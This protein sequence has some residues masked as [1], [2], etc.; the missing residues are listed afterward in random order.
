MKCNVHCRLMV[1]GRS[2]STL[3]VKGNV[4]YK[5]CI[6]RHKPMLKRGEYEREVL[7]GGDVTGTYCYRGKIV[8]KGKK[9]DD[10]VKNAMVIW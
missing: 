9:R 6:H 5:H 2:I 10:S 4:S 3:Y 8:R 1:Q 7:I